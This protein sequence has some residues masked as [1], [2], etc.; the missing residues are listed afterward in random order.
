MSHTVVEGSGL[1]DLKDM[2]IKLNILDW[3]DSAGHQSR[4]ILLH[5]VVGKPGRWRPQ[6]GKGSAACVPLSLKP[7]MCFLCLPACT[8]CARHY[9]GCSRHLSL[10]RVTPASM[11]SWQCGNRTLFKQSCHW[12]HVYA[13]KH[14]KWCIPFAP[15]ITPTTMPRC[16]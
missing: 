12:V 15:F 2:W 8:Q 16:E 3:T 1:I 4:Y 7:K 10:P 9:S 13:T 6:C 14:R 5:R 11:L